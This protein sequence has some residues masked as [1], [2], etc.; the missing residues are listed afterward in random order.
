MPHVDLDHSRLHYVVEGPG[1][2]PALVLSHSIGANLSMWDFVSPAFATRYKVIRYDTRGH[3][4]SDTPSGPYSIADLGRDALALIDAL[5]IQQC[6][7]CGLSLGGMIGVWLAIH[8]PH[9]IEKLVLANTA[10]RIGTEDLWN[11][12]IR[13]VRQGGLAT[14]TDAIL[15]RWFTPQ[16]WQNSPAITG[17]I[18]TMLASTSSEGYANCCAAIRDEDLRSNLHAIAAPALIITGA[19]DPATPPRDGQFL[20]E[21]IPHAKLVELATSHLSA[22]EDPAGFSSAVLDF[23]GGQEG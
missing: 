5:Q 17:S 14:M 1:D 11:E 3:G 20:A 13:Q 4:A 15:A 22:I 23:L 2:A 6:C 10:A 16:F 12:R 18:R 21:G 19:E 9:R 8:A 7:F